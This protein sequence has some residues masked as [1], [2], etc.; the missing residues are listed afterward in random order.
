MSKRLAS[1]M[2]LLIGLLVAALPSGCGQEG[3][4][5]VPEY[6][7]EQFMRTLAIVGGS[8]SPAEQRVLYS[9]DETGV[10][11]AY[12]I[13]VGGGEATQLTQSTDNAIFALSYFPTGDRM[14]F[15]GDL[16]GDE[17]FHL[18]MRQEDGTLQN[19]TPFPGVHAIFHGWSLDDQQLYFG[20]NRRDRRVRD[21]YEMD[22]AT[23]TSKL[24]YA[25]DH[26]YEFAAVDNGQRHI[27]L[28]QYN[29]TADS[30][31]HLFDR[32]SGLTRH[33]TPHAG[34][35]KH[36]AL[37]FSVDSEYLFYLTDAEYEFTYLQTLHLA[38]GRTEQV[39]R[40]DWDI[41]GSVLS[42]NGTYRA[43]IINRDGSSELRITETA[44][45][46]RLDLPDLPAGLFSRVAFSRSENLVRFYVN[47]PTA[48]NDLYVCDLQ[49][50]SLSKL[51]SSLNT[52]VDPKHLA[53][54]TVVRFRS[55][56]GLE[57]PA[58]YY[59]PL[60]VEAGAKIP[61][62]VWVHVGPGGQSKMDY[63]GLGQYLVNH[64]YAF[65]AVN[66]RG[67]S[68]Y[69]KTFYHADDH[70]HGEA[71]L[72][73]CVA[74]KHFL[75]DTGYV[76]AEKIGIIGGSYGGYLVLAALAFQPEE[77]AVGVDIFGV[78]NWLRALSIMPMGWE[79]RRQA[80]FKELGNP[81]T[82]ADY[83]IGISPLFHADRIVRPLMV[84]Q[85]ASD[86]RVLQSESDEMVATLRKNDVPVEYLIFPDEG[87]G[88][89][90]QKNQI[91][92]YRA[93]LRF[94]DTHL[95]REVVTPEG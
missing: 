21:V 77:F 85:G 31:I 78:S 42:R 33:L 13:P 36:R 68:G 16:G 32:R 57:I 10:L 11:N 50:R 88:F 12:S 95:K 35:I 74:A 46:Q 72:A 54:A 61:A 90:K 9:S 75:I 73:D 89:L 49:R 14:L 60:A 3:A 2:G 62:L 64:G 59:K 38:S 94:L 29:T 79:A 83:L 6:T 82:E 4:R 53:P 1:G 55:A 30:D 23:L 41:D 20:T 25:N 27:A 56:D 8:F 58:I 52:E 15:S 26:G 18:L 86:P 34:D 51:T 28:N 5:E 48:P 43:I 47:G 71:D 70:R 19:L 65:L 22:L 66:H 37:Y 80:I 91:E 93:I 63:N 39:E 44:T 40:L 67:S 7:C 76:D 87:H 17:I 92:G 24:V 69:G 84:L 45:G 81:E